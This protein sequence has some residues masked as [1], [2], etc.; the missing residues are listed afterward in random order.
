MLNQYVEVGGELDI[1][2]DKGVWEAE[3]WWG[4]EADEME[5]GGDSVRWMRSTM[6]GQVAL[7]MEKSNTP[8]D[9]AITER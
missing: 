2:R 5:W 4:D 8:V 3:A 9:L 6:T 1:L 7:G